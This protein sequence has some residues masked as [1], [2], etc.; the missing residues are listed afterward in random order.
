[1]ETLYAP[2]IGPEPATI[3][4]NGHRVL[5]LSHDQCELEETLPLLGGDTVHAVGDG[6]EDSEA[7]AQKFS[8]TKAHI[9]ITP[10]EASVTEVLHSLEESLPWLQ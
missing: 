10:T 7:L 8:G 2:Y 4:V 1:M 6:G 3:A 9:V 5:V